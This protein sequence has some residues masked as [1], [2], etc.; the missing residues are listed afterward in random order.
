MT[1]LLDIYFKQE[2]QFLNDESKKH[3]IIDL[4][5]LFRVVFNKFFNQFKLIVLDETDFVTTQSS[6]EKTKLVIS[7]TNRRYTYHEA[8]VGILTLTAYSQGMTIAISA[9]KFPVFSDETCINASTLIDKKEI[10]DVVKYIE[11]PRPSNIPINKLVIYNLVNKN[12]NFT[13]FK[14]MIIRSSNGKSIFYSPVKWASSLRKAF[15]FK[16]ACIITR[17]ENQDVKYYDNKKDVRLKD[18]GGY[19]NIIMIGKTNDEDDNLNDNIMQK[20]DM[21]AVN[22]S[23]SRAVS[24]I[25]KYENSQIVIMGDYI[26][27]GTTQIMGRFRNS[28]S[29][30]ILLT[31]NKN[32]DITLD[33][34][35]KIDNKILKDVEIEKI[36]INS[37]SDCNKHRTSGFN[38]KLTAVGKT[39]SEL[40][41][42]KYLAIEIFE[43]EKKQ[44]ILNNKKSDVL[45]IYLDFCKEKKYP[46]VSRNTLWSKLNYKFDK[47]DINKE[48]V[49]SSFEPI[50]NEDIFN[51][52]IGNFS[53]KPT[54]T[55]FKN[56]YKFLTGNIRWSQG[57]FKNNHRK[58]DNW[59]G[60]VDVMTFDVDDGTTIKEAIKKIENQN[61]KALI[62]PTKSHQILKNDKP[63]CD[64]FR[65]V[66]PLVETFKGDIKEW[67]DKYILVAKSLEIEIDKSCK[68]ISR[69]FF[70]NGKNDDKYYFTNGLY[71]LDLKKFITPIIKPPIK[72]KK[73]NYN[74]KNN[75]EDKDKRIEFYENS[76]IEDIKERLNFDVNPSPGRN[77]FLFGKMMFLKKDVGLNNDRIRELLLALNEYFTKPLDIKELEN[78]IFKQL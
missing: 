73:V 57:T 26:N 34:L 1:N 7:V 19:K 78:T 28:P 47:F 41:K 9:N 5:H 45:K 49:I 46:T 51:F 48:I 60:T 35:D 42:Q 2:E 66:F 53:F 72:K 70:P 50:N 38:S 31:N 30:I 58:I 54:K 71:G 16:N 68:D 37:L 65:V 59:L 74:Y 22:M 12:I 52:R 14:D 39:V 18:I 4:I 23:S 44:D 36:N 24:L 61:L 29:D 40:T 67:S 64:R 56:L 62:V 3:S 25:E 43:K 77:A 69:F 27:T 75:Y 21:V 63:K 13:R 8:M 17:Q 55:T 15:K 10:L 20:N 32:I 6:M 33:E 76:D 11:N